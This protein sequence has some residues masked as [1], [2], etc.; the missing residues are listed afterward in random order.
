MVVVGEEGFKERK[1]ISKLILAS[2]GEEKTIDA[3]RVSG[4]KRFKLERVQVFFPLGS[5]FELEVKIL[6]GSEQVKPTDG[7]YRGDGNVVVDVTGVWFG[8]DEHIK[9]WYKNNSST[10]NRAA[11]V[12]L[13]GFEE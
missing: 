8:S 3:Y 9:I 7:S 1:S 6:R 11:T 13:E 4:G 2:P 12:L 10:D 5:Y